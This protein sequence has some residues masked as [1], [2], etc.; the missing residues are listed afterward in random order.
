M[1][2]MSP[3]ARVD[4]AARAEERQFHSKKVRVTVPKALLCSPRRIRPEANC[5][6]CCNGMR[7]MRPGFQT[8]LV[9]FCSGSALNLIRD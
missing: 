4:L 2:A 7:S 6:K 1:H 9:Y 5:A 8:S 3:R